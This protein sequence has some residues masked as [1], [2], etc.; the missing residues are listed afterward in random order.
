MEA[1]GEY[2]LGRVSL[3]QT[4]ESFKQTLHR[5]ASNEIFLAQIEATINKRML[6]IYSLSLRPRLGCHDF[7]I[8]HQPKS[9][10]ILVGAVR[11]VLATS[12]APQSK[13]TRQET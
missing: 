3:R 11:F 7:T 9:L 13:A 2:L 12:S 5:R 8:Y 6:E 10:I 4:W 1:G